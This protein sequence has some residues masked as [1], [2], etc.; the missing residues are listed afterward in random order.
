MPLVRG[1]IAQPWESSHTCFLTV[2]IEKFNQVATSEHSGLVQAQF[3]N[4]K[5]DTGQNEG[6]YIQANPDPQVAGSTFGNGLKADLI[7]A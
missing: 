5:V 2:E 7:E 4:H 1:L 3:P 6:K